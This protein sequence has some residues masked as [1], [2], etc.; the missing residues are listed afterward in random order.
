M[1]QSGQDFLLI[2]DVQAAFR[3]RPDI[4]AGLAALAQR[5]SAAATIELHNENRTPFA[6][7]LGWKPAVEDHCMIEGVPVFVKHGYLPPD[8]LIAHIHAKSPARVLVGGVQADTCVMA[9][10]FRLF[11]EGLHPTMLAP[12]CQ[13]SSADPDGQIARRLWK[14]HFGAIIEKLNELPL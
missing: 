14:H 8:D 11:D 3:P 4:V 7:Q 5:L 12:L 13:G 10:G 2:V 6:R 1:A 9:A